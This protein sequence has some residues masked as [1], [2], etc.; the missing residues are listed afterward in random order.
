MAHNITVLS[1]CLRGNRLH[2]PDI[3]PYV[4][5]QTCL[6]SLRDLCFGFS[7]P[8]GVRNY[9]DLHSFCC[10]L[11]EF[12]LDLSDSARRRRETSR[13]HSSWE[14]LPREWGEH[15]A[16]YYKI[17][18]VPDSTVTNALRL[19]YTRHPYPTFLDT[20][21]SEL[22]GLYDDVLESYLGLRAARFRRSDFSV[23]IYRRPSQSGAR[24]RP[25]GR[26]TP[27]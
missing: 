25:P 27:S 26:T 2:Q 3:H 17:W 4:T 16:K 21:E 9:Q 13:Y 6:D 18:P 20:S 22:G 1:R 11:D 10:V 8:P 12:E 23:H 19:E 5:S 15:D 24:L 7:V 14:G